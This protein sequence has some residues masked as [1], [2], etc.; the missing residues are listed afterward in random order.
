MV[1]SWALLGVGRV[2]G[3]LSA[4]IAMSVIVAFVAV[5]LSVGS[6]LPCTVTGGNCTTALKV[7]GVVSSDWAFVWANPV[8]MAPNKAKL[9]ARL[10]ARAAVLMV[11]VVSVVMVGSVYCKVM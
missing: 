10:K 1:Q 7:A 2:D 8:S 6:L 3:A 5:R 11:R 9:T 4:V